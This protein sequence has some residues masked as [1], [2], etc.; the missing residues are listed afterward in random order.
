M[1]LGDFHLYMKPGRW[2]NSGNSEDVR[3]T[4]GLNLEYYHSILVHSIKI[5]RPS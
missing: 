4:F 2:P 3:G 1:E 5:I